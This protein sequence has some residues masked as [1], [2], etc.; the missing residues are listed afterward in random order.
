MHA[1]FVWHSDNDNTS[2]T[3]ALNI[4]W[5]GKKIKI[6]CNSRNYYAIKYIQTGCQLSA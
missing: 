4:L 5:W 1:Y 3:R 6:T 2:H